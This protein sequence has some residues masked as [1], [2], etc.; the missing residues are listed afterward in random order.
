L[1]GGILWISLFAFLLAGV[2]AVNVAV[3][4]AHVGVNQ[5]DKQQLQLQQV[6]QQISGQILPVVHQVVTSQVMQQVPQI[7]AQLSAGY[8]G[9][10][11]QHA[12]AQQQQ[13]LSGWVSAIRP[14]PF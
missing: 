3:L 8:L 7:V 14:Y 1:R 12:F 13:P 9:Q 6:I 11:G 4:R 10:Q 2:V 5:L